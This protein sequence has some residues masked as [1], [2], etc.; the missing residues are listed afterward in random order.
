MTA[1][2]RLDDRT[3]SA[4]REA[5]VAARAGRMEDACRI[6]REALDNGG[7]PA[8]L[9]AM[10]GSLHCRA[11]DLGTGIGHLRAAR[12]A[13]PSDPVIAANLAAAYIERSEH[14]AALDV[15]SDDLAKAD[16]SLRLQRMRG[17]AAQQIED[18]PTAIAAYMAVVEA[19]PSDWETWNNLGNAR[20]SAGDLAGGV[21]ALRRAAALNPQAA[22]TRLNLCRALRDAGQDAEAEAQLRAMAE[23]F[24]RDAKPLVDLHALLQLRERDDG[25]AEEALRNAVQREPDDIELR[26]ALARFHASCFAMDQAEQEFRAILMQD[27][28]NE[29]AFVDL[30]LMGEQSKPAILDKLVE[31]AA[32]AGVSPACLNLVRAFAD[33]RAKRHREG[34]AALQT[35]PHDYQAIHRSQLEGQLLDAVADYDAAFAAFSRMNEKQ[36]EDPSRPEDRAARYRETVRSQMHALSPGWLERYRAAEAGDAADGRASPV[37]LVGFPRSGTTLLDTMLMGHPDAH[38]LE[39]EPALVKAARLFPTFESIPSA[40]E[41]QVKAARDEYFRVAARSAPLT[42]GKV[43]I[44]KNPL[45]MN[46]LPVMRRLFPDARVILAVRHP[47]DV[48]LSC[49]VTNFKLN[50]GMSSFLRLDTAAELY[51]LSFS[52]FEQASQMLE[53]PVHRVLYENVVV[54]RERELRALLEFIGLEWNDQVLDHETTALNRGQIKTASYAQVPQ[55]IYNRSAGRWANYRKHLEPILPALE[56]WVTRFG[57]TL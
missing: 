16:R 44:D 31:E 7:E 39:E 25:E 45:S 52:Y 5:L 1:A 6:G 8:A 4:I 18:Y 12:D 19:E 33:R 26:L 24:P 30:A 32:A 22:P 23:D 11:G 15:L 49:F 42:P 53:L 40:T 51:D 43:L 57:Y 47:C 36:K 27:P 46:A 28:V 35:V 29:D 10:L 14:G 54:D 37:F 48:V 20:V 56:P 2:S 3:A 9:N 55:P 21:E 38:V 50:D 13:R 17:F 34:L 41:E